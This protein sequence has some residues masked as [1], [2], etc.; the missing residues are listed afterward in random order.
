[1]R[2]REGRGSEPTARSVARFTTECGPPITA[3]NENGIGDR[4]KLSTPLAYD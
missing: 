3:I 2:G 4:I 1:M